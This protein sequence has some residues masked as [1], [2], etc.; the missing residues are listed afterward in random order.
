MRLNVMFTVI[1]FCGVWIKREK[2]NKK[3]FQSNSPNLKG[4]IHT[5][6]EILECLLLSFKHFHLFEIMYTK[7]SRTKK[8][9]DHA[10]TRK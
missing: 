9:Q 6:T 1:S 8:H 5:N 4:N 3:S 7:E 10:C 2:E